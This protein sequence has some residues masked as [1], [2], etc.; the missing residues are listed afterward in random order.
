M[1]RQ[2][3]KSITEAFDLHI[4]RLTAELNT[5]QALAKQ[6]RWRHAPEW[7]NC[8]VRPSKAGLRAID[9]YAN[10]IAEH[11]EHQPPPQLIGPQNPQHED[12]W[13]WAKRDNM[14][15]FYFDLDTDMKLF[16]AA[17]AGTWTIEEWR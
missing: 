1:T 3:F 6:E 4:E 12:D 15:S 11:P 10:Y 14:G 13:R 2:A 7:A 9:Y 8:I 17:E 5:C 16:V